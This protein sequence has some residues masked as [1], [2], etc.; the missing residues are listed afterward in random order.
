[1]N[2]SISMNTGIALNVPVARAWAAMTEPEHVAKLMWGTQLDTTWEVGTPIFF[3]GE[4]EGK[5]Y[6]DKGTVLAY[7]PLRLVSYDYHSSMSPPSGCARTLPGHHLYLCRNRNRLLPGD[8]PGQFPGP[9][10]Q[11]PLAG[12]LGRNADPSETNA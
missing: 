1:M 7:E 4:W 3:R 9:A 11:R 10:D 2:T 12:E 6:E 8:Q 5:S